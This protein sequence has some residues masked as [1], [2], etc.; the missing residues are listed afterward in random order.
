[1]RRENIV[2]IA[3]GAIIIAFAAYF[4]WPVKPSATKVT[5]RAVKAVEN[6]VTQNQKEIEKHRTDIN[7]RVV[8]IR[9][10]VKEDT[11]HLDPDALV[12]G[13]LRELDL[14]RRAAP[15]NSKQSP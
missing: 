13:V 1:M 11:K 8:Y 7:G 15:N 3:I 5:D 6:T 4:F 2:W 10:T 9:E 12:I 14:F